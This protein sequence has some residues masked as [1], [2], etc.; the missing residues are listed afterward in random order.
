[1]AR[2]TRKLSILRLFESPQAEQ[3]KAAVAQTVSGQHLHITPPSSA[4]PTS[5]SFAATVPATRA[6]VHSPSELART[7]QE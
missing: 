3:F 4:W 5:T 1:M 6:A 7:Y 2:A